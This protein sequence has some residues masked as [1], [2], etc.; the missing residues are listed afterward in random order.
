MPTV[1]TESALDQLEWEKLRL[2]Q[3]AYA[4][5]L[6]SLLK[7]HE[8][9]YVALHE[10]AVIAT[11]AN[12]RELHVQVYYLLGDIPVLFKRVSAEPEPDLRIRSPRLY[13][14]AGQMDVMD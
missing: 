14:Q 9:E 3:E 11:G 5:L 13:D 8:G 1:A 12:L 6:P 7:T 10:G 4:S 2:E